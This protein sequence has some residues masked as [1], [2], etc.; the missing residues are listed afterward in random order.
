MTVMCREVERVQIEKGAGGLFGRS[1]RCWVG[2]RPR[3]RR[4]LGLE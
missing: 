1:L 3:C 2:L 4:R